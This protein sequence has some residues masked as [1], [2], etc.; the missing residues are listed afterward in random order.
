[1]FKREFWAWML[2]KKLGSF[3]VQTIFALVFIIFPL[4]YTFPFSWILSII[5][6]GW[7][8]FGTVYRQYTIFK[9]V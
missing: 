3:T 1:M 5:G 8:L 4:V 7:W 9:K 2:T 6:V